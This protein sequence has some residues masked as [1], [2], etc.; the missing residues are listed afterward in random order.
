MNIDKIGIPPDLEVKNLEKFT[1]EEEE[2]YV[3]LLNSNVI[4]DYVEKHPNMSEKEISA[5]AN[6][7]RKTYALD[8]RLLRRLIR[9]QV[10]K[11]RTDVYYDLDFDLQL[12]EAIKLIN[13]TKDFEKLLKGTKTLKQLQD[14]AK[15]TETETK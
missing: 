5:K 8:A 11:N 7:I 6:E 9:V 3:K 10:L 4:N 2:L 13:N 14:E 15:L 1:P 12:N